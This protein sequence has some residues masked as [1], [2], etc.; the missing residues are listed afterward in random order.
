MS[1]NDAGERQ[2]QYLP[3]YKW[4]SDGNPHGD[5]LPVEEGL[6]RRSPEARGKLLDD[7]G[8]EGKLITVRDDGTVN[9]LTNYPIQDST[10]KVSRNFRFPL[11]QYNT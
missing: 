9:P 10:K 3:M 7:P 5:A 11:N 8:T 2:C 4:D 1:G 6:S